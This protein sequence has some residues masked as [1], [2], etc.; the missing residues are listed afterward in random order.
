MCAY[1]TNQQSPKPCESGARSRSSLAAPTLSP[2]GSS[3]N[4]SSCSRESFPGSPL[5][6]R[7]LSRDWT[8][9]TV[10]T[11]TNADLYFHFLNHTC[12]SAPRCHKNRIVLQIGIAKLALDSEPVSHSVLALSA[13]CL[14]CDTISNGNGDPETVRRILDLGLQH[15]TLALEQMHTLTCRQRDTDVQPLLVC[16]LML[17][18]FALAFQHIQHWVLRSAGLGSPDLLT[19]RDAVLLL[20]GIGTTI[21][22]LNS[23]PAD[24]MS[25]E[26]KTPFDAMFSSQGT[27]SEHFEA[28]PEL[29]HTMFPV[30]AGTYHQALSHLQCRCDS[31]VA[32]TEADENIASAVN[33]YE[34]LRNIMS[35]TFSD[36]KTIM[37]SPE[38][39]T[40][41][42]LPRRC[43]GPREYC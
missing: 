19:P 31:A 26:S 22:A 14:C 18:P 17:V 12:K 20:R 29:P 32:T 35:D 5:P 9:H 7:A 8:D 3:K 27:T 1:A 25:P 41:V 23:N 4:L 21:V 15:H 13:A 39:I 28:M 38:C 10:S 33:A 16:A 2:Y 30:L 36:S 34:V 42:G 43:L 37:V 40:H 24:R 6:T 11:L